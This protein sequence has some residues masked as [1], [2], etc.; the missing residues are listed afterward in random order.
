MSSRLEDSDRA[1]FGGSP[2]THGMAAAP[3]IHTVRG[4]RLAVV[5][6]PGEGK[7]WQSEGDRCSIGSFANNAFVIED[8]TVSR[9]HCEVR[10]DADGARAVAIA[11]SG[12]FQF[13]TPPGVTPHSVLHASP[14]SSVPSRSSSNAMCPGV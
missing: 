7:A 1:G 8:R 13:V 9:Y 10:I 6:G 11:G 5:E 12:N 3:A 4:F 2:M 14:A